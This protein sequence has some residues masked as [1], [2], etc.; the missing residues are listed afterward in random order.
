M[1]GV[2]QRD[3][4]IDGSFGQDAVPQVE[5]VAGTAACARENVRGAGANEVR[6]AEELDGVKIA[7]HGHIAE[8]LPSV[9]E[10]NSPVE[11]DAIAARRLH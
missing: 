11:A 10:V 8:A 6:A 4:V 7:H 2:N 3:N 9:T 1:Y 5:D